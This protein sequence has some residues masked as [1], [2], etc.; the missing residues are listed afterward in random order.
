MN[1]HAGIERPELLTR[2]IDTGRTM[3]KR[4]FV[5]TALLLMMTTNVDALVV[6][7]AIRNGDDR[8]P[9]AI[10]RHHRSTAAPTPGVMH[11]MNCANA[12]VSGAS[13]MARR[14]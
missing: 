14:S 1:Y 8:M 12:C 7:R 3:K 6:P 11:W 9:R 2:S 10:T 4:T 13:V 5:L